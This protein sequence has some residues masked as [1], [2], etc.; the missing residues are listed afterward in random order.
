MKRSQSKLFG[1]AKRY[2][3]PPDVPTP[4]QRTIN[5]IKWGLAY[6]KEKKTDAKE[7][8][9][10][11]KGHGT[12]GVRVIKAPNGKYG[13]YVKPKT[14]KR[15]KAKTGQTGKSVTAIDKKRKAKK[16]GKRVSKSGKRYTE[17]RANRSDKNPSKRL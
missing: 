8:A 16:P 15:K 7:I 6:A 11:I 10:R 5:G 9:K 2:R 17:R 12:E 14:G 4:E 1:N 13:V 3:P